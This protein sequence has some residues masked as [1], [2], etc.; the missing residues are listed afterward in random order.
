MSGGKKRYCI[1]ESAQIFNRNVAEKV[2]GNGGPPAA[3]TVGLNGC[4]VGL[5][6]CT[7][8]LSSI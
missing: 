2:E 7:A 3:T 1:Y 8:G 4:T 5:N 6:G